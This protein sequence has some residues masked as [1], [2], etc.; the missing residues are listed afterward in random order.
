MTTWDVLIGN[1]SLPS[2]TAWDH[3]NAQ[4]GGGSGEVVYIPASIKAMI[5]SDSYHKTKVSSDQSYNVTMRADN[6][7]VVVEEI[8]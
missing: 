3:L 6:I 4:T 2:G 1:S 7:K 5:S 8:D